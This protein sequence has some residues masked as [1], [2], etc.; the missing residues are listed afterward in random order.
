VRCRP[1]N[2]REKGLKA[3][4]IIDVEDGKTVIIADPKK[5][6][7][8]QRFTFDHS[9]FWDSEQENVYDALGKPIM[10]GAIAGFNGTIFAYGQTG[11]GKTFSMMGEEGME[12]IIPR[13][14]AGLFESLSAAS[15]AADAEEATE[16]DGESKSAPAVDFLV[17]V[18]YLEIY[19]EVIKDLLNPS[20]KRLEVREHPKLGIYVKDLA[21][22]VVKDAVSVAALIEQ[23]NAVRQVATT[24]MNA[25]S[26][27]SHSCFI[28]RI[29]QKRTERVRTGKDAEV[30]RTTT[31][32]A[33]LNLVDLAGSE[34]QAKTG[35]TGARLKEGAAINKSLTALG[36]VINALAATAKKGDH[37]PYRDSKLTRLLQESLGG[38]SMT[39]MLAAISPADDNFEET[40]STLRYANRAKNIQNKA[41]R[42]ED[43]NQAIINELR[44]E[45][46]HLRKQLLLQQAKGPAAVDADPE[47]A[48]R[49]AA[50]V[51]SLEDTIAALEHA[52]QQSWEQQQA[53]SQA[54][55]EERKK[56]LANTDK[57]KSVM[58]TLKEDNLET[59]RRLKQLDAS[60]SKETRRFRSLRDKHKANRAQMA[61]QMVEWQRLHELDGGREDGPHAEE[62]AAALASVERL[63]D[64]VEAEQKELMAIKGRIRG[65]DDEREE[66]RAEA[67]AQRRLLEQDADLRRTIADE[68]RRRLAA[69]AET[70]L[71][72]HM[73]E[74]RQALQEEADRERQALLARLHAAQEAGG[75]AS[76][77]EVDGLRLELLEA[78]RDRDVAQ[79]T[80]DSARAQLDAAVERVRAEADEASHAAKVR[81]L[82]MVR[83]IVEGYEDERKLLRQQAAEMGAHLEAAAMDIE[84]LSRQVTALRG[85]LVVARAGGVA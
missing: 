67:S 40:I 22:L 71:K 62:I 49:E 78:K 70:E 57:I 20:D 64:T 34:R 24:N 25:R 69:E 59:L 31:T 7:D 2:S 61:E 5:E 52:K 18:S 21:T 82:R 27:R 81:E 15:A 56:N 65:I 19:N 46:E 30:E 76:G 73:Q 42:N 26:S 58:Q 14:N 75:G 44:G 77:A 29:E 32:N 48:A 38:N 28:I 17:S 85:E 16:V 37:V 47:E 83:S 1:F 84:E 43:V 68:E 63:H 79:L 39:L 50:K 35:A 74:Q 72:R 8:P 53:L 4:C 54:Y 13:L 12:G 9:Y 55:E 36:N 45:I 66:V 3:E 6:K 10:E 11:S 33:K 41:K 23:G 51:T 60:A 80:A